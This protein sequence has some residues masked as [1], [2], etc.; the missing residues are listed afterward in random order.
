MGTKT[1]PRLDEFVLAV[2][3][4]LAGLILVY[5]GTVGFISNYTEIIANNSSALPRFVISFGLLCLGVY[6]LT[7]S[8]RVFARIRPNPPLWLDNS[9][10]LIFGFTLLAGFFFT[11]FT[12]SVLILDLFN[13]EHDRGVLA[14]GIVTIACLVI[15]AIYQFLWSFNAFEPFIPWPLEFYNQATS[16][17]R[18]NLLMA[19]LLRLNSTQHA[20]LNHGRQGYTLEKISGP[21]LIEPDVKSTVVTEPSGGRPGLEK[22]LVAHGGWHVSTMGFTANGTVIFAVSTGGT[23][24]FR[25]GGRKGMLFPPEIKFWEFHSDKIQTASLGQPYVFLTRDSQTP[26]PLQNY[27][28]LVPEGGG[29]FTLL[30]P[31]LIRVGDWQNSL[32]HDFIPDEPLIL[33]SQN[34]FTPLA[35]NPEGSRVAWCDAT[36]QTNCWNMQ[37]DKVQ[38]LRHYPAFD[39]TSGEMLVNDASQNAW[40]LVFSPDG[41]KV[42]TIGSHGVLLQNVYTGWRWFAANEPATERLTAFA[43]NYN[44]FEMAVGLTLREDKVKRPLRR[45]RYNSRPFEP[46][47]PAEPKWLNVVRIWDLRLPDYLDLTTGE[48]P[49]REIAFSPD[50]QMV[51]AVDEAGWLWLW[52][53]PVEGTGGRPPRLVS[54]VDLGIS[55]RK[56]VAIFSPDMQRLICATDNRLLVFSISRL[57]TEAPAEQYRR[58]DVAPARETL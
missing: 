13:N 38:S 45:S 54:Q 19:M 12:V 2:F 16:P 21:L 50:N 14:W 23:V 35:F 30:T 22:V 3:W 55:G 52:D 31:Y 41:T 15:L 8:F 25:A 17:K 46:A 29:K 47:A 44:G 9:G 7:Y 39:P 53:V 43:F 6:G 51:A 56:T 24:H 20:V 1:R 18:V 37:D 4:V 26:T 5:F 34:G 48:Q 10:P 58:S 32:T 36:G 40:G 11:L 28:F 57:R 33:Q 42:A 27:R 49:L